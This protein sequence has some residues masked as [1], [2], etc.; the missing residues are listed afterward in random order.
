MRCS[1][2]EFARFILPKA[3]VDFPFKERNFSAAQAV[4]GEEVESVF[5]DQDHAAMVIK[6]KEHKPK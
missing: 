5:A 2:E 1:F 6:F 3:T 4:F